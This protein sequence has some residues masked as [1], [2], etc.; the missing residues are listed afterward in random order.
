MALEEKYKILVRKMIC[1]SPSKL[2]EEILKKISE[3]PDDELKAHLDKW[4]AERKAGLAK[5]IA[6]AQKELAGI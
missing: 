1:S 4:A 5:A 3:T 2:T 6:A